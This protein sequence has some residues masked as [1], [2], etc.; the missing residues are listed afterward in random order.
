MQRKKNAMII[1]VNNN[2][3][4]INWPRVNWLIIQWR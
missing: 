3:N 4:I 2:G 1:S